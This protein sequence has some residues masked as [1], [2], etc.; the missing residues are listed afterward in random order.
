MNKKI[1]SIFLGLFLL[2]PLISGCGC[3]RSIIDLDYNYSHA[4][5]YVN[6][7]WKY[8]EIKKWDDYDNDAICIWA[9][10]GSVYYTHLENVVLVN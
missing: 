6:G 4:Y 1:I 3:N 7:E 9:K 8:V 2:I 10:D 5:I